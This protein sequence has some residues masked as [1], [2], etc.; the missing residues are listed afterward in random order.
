MHWTAKSRLGE[1][2]EAAAVCTNSDATSNF[3]VTA[4]IKA[5]TTSSGNKDGKEGKRSH[6]SAHADCSNHVWMQ[7]AII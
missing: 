5:W 3:I 7:C 1:E 6:R 2:R 4:K